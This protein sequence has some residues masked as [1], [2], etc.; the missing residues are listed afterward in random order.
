MAAALAE[1]S[2]ALTRPGGGAHV[3]LDLERGALRVAGGP[4]VPL[5]PEALERAAIEQ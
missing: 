3:E 2:E 4:D 5:L 1:L